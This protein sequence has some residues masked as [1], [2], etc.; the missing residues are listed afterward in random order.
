MPAYVRMLLAGF[1]TL[2]LAGAAERDIAK[3]FAV[4]PGCTLQVDS[5]RGRLTV[6][7]GDT[8]EVAV[9]IH[10]ETGVEAGPEAERIF[11]ALQLELKA[12]GNVVSVRAR[13]PDQTRVR[14]FWEEEK[15][16]E[17]YYRITVPRQ[18]SVNL[19]VG[20]G[21]ITVGNLAGRHTAR[22]RNGNISFKRIDGAV[23]ARTGMGS[24]IVSRCSGAV[25]VQT[26]E[27]VIRVGTIGGFADLRNGSGEIEVLQAKAGIVAVAEAG[28]ISVGFPDDLGQE[29]SVT[30]SGGSIFAKI[31]AAANCS[32]DAASVW[33]HVESKLPLTVETG[34]LGKRKLTAKLNAGGPVITLRASG[35]D[36]KIAKLDFDLD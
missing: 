10:L 16:I 34:G 36:V 35:G 6:E 19:T 32:V 30:V 2:P 25:T 12:E 26:R 9:A 8:A 20:T 4:Q 5:Y 13:N 7:E 24:V 29:N 33:G 18:C 27:G 1:A 3:T 31:D 22:V 21:S 14:W 15:Q 28:D 17:L 23:D 11:A